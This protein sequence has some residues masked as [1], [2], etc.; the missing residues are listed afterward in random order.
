[1]YLLVNVRFYG[2]LEW[3]FAFITYK[4][5]LVS[6]QYGFMVHIWTNTIIAYVRDA[7]VRRAYVSVYVLDCSP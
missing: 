3:L 5:Q 2:R 4:G 7:C 1:M 6:Y